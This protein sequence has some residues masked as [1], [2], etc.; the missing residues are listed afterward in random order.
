MSPQ[1]VFSILQGLLFLI[2]SP[3]VV[4]ALRWCEARRQGRGR[5]IRAM[6][7][8]Y[9]D[10]VKLMRA[11]AVRPQTA[12]W[13]FAF[14]PYALL[15]VYGLLAFTLPLF[16]AP[17]L[18]ID[19]VTLIYLLGAVRFTLSLAGWDAGA[20]FGNLGGGREMYMQFWTE[21]ALILTVTGLVIRWGELNLPAILDK[22]SQLLRMGV[23]AQIQNLGLIFLFPAMAIAVFLEAGRIPVDNPTTHLE[24]T[25]ANKAILLEF[26]G[27]D[28]ALIEAAEAVKLSF[29]LVLLAQLFIRPLFAFGDAFNIASLLLSVIAT[30]LLLAWWET[31][32][33]K[34]RLGRVHSLS[35]NAIAFALIAIVIIG[36]TK[37]AFQ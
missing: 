1:P 16:T 32:R 5:N 24:L 37:G 12:S 25:M 33:P 31:G 27:T 6:L 26:A 10:L 20:S 21:L 34:I 30:T 13:L 17:L 14:T 35:G 15:V 8:P 18:S 29:L 22:H 9:F 2:L 23:D 4:G 28:L 19:V 7:Q 11:P 36:L 3:L